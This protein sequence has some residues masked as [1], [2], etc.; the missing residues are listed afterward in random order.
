MKFV[1]ISD[2]HGKHNLVKELPAADCIIHAGDVSNVGKEHEVI[3]FL[4]W[5]SNLDYE[6]KIFIAGNHDFF[7]E[8]ADIDRIKAVIPENIIYLN[9]SYTIINDI[10]I[11]GSPVSPW[12]Y[13][14]AFN[15]I[16]GEEI[17]K[18][19]DQIP[20]DTDILI[21]HGP[22]YEILDKTIS[23][24]K[25]GCSDLL[26]TVNQIKP[27]LHICGHIHEAYGTY[28]NENT[29]FINACLLD[30]RYIMMNCPVLFELKNTQKLN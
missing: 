15:R 10:K 11:W 27:K 5:Y 2:T 21:T 4:D 12:F 19:W 3:D 23:G 29:K 13:D 1:A 20:D 9:D 6:Y 17:K 30:E 18:H 28:E 14:W 16:R 25:T 7:F 8:R 24:D 22:V 26:E